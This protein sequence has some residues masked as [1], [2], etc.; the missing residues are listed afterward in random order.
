M[1]QGLRV[2]PCRYFSFSCCR[3]I[4]S[5][6]ESSSYRKISSCRKISSWQ[7]NS[8]CRKISSWQEINYFHLTLQVW[9]FKDLYKG[10]G[11]TWARTIGLMT[12]YFILIDSMRRNMS[13]QFSTPLLGPFLASGVA[14]TTAWWIVWPLENMKSQV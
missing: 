7:E 6:Q 1:Y 3:K 11:I 9:Y 14:A 8:S 5:W 4:S 13:E 10:F 2:T 12:T